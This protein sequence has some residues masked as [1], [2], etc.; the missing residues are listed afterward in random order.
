MSVKI[1]L[2]CRLSLNFS[3]FV[4]KFRLMINKTIFGNNF[5][6]YTFVAKQSSLFNSHR[7]NS[8]QVL[9]FFIHC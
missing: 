1:S 7:L 4:G 6:S 8:I 5:I 9:N 3:I 2:L